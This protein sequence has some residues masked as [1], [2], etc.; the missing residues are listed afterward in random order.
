V[1]ERRLIG[2]IGSGQDDPELNRLAEEVGGLIA[3]EGFVLVNG[4]LGGVMEGSAR[5]A[6]GA[7]GTTVG[8]LPGL[9]PS[10]ANPYIDIPVS[11]GLGE[12]RNLLI[13]RAAS[14][15][16]AIGGGYG[17]LS[18]IAL[19]LKV[20]RPVVGLRTWDVS[21]EITIA[22]SAADALYRVMKAVG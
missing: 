22:E 13:V 8:I 14:A 18:E 2:V 11:T 5:G 4:G 12:G 16:I 17:T 9:D 6:K 10:S 19:A 15:L 1:T 3:S 7:G 21:T 20:G